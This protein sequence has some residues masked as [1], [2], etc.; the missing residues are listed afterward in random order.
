VVTT[1]V[2]E[3][4]SKDIAEL[5]AERAERGWD[6]HLAERQLIVRVDENTYT[7]P[8]CSG[9]GTYIVHYGNQVEDCECVDFQVHH[10]S[11]KHLVAVALFHATRRRAN[12][13][14]EVCGVGS[15]EKSLMGLRNDHSKGGPKYCLPHY[16]ESMSQTFLSVGNIVLDRLSSAKEREAAIQDEGV[17]S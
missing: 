11:C 1:I 2:K 5:I 3:D 4:T 10:I 12:S 7:V 16:P 9:R 8:S 15:D 14:C 13:K 6:L 17:R